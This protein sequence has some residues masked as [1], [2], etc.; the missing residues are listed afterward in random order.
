MVG[1]GYKLDSLIQMIDTRQR[2]L[3]QVEATSDETSISGSL[4]A[5]FKDVPE[6]TLKKKSGGRLS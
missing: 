6:L 1:I 5:F 2:D 3:T 4:S